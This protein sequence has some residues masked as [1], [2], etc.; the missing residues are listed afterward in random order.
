LIPISL[1]L[2]HLSNYRHFEKY[3]L[4]VPTVAMLMIKV[5]MMIGDFSLRI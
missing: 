1:T 2:R 3:H 5:I 4:K